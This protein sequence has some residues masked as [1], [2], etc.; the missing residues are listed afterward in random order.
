MRLT[1]KGKKANYQCQNWKGK[2]HYWS[3]R[4]W[5]DRSMLWTILQQHNWKFEWNGY[6]LIKTNLIKWKRNRPSHLY[7][8]RSQ[9]SYVCVFM[10]SHSVMS[11]SLQPHGPQPARLLSPWDFPG[12]NTEVNCYFL[13]HRI[14][15]TQGSTGLLHW[16]VDSLTTAP[17]GKPNEG[18]I[19]HR[20]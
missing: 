13:L 3:F 18:M 2:Y 16:Q 5:K 8:C 6:I 9:Q 1:L 20:E 15:L 19:R 12:N 10:L 11:K 4:H 7:T 14:F 17:L